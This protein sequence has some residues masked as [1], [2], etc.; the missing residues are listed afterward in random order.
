MWPGPPTSSVYVYSA[1]YN[2]DGEHSI[3]CALCTYTTL[4][5]VAFANL[6]QGGAKQASSSRVS[7]SLSDFP[8]PPTRGI[9]YQA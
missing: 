9:K 6:V 2:F 1:V 3:K 5:F 4:A 8:E 7:L